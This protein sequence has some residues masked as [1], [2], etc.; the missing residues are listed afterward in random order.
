MHRIFSTLVLLVVALFHVQP[1][2]TAL[3]WQDPNN[4][5]QNPGF[6]GDYYPWMNLNTA[7]VAHGWTPWWRSR[8]DGDPKAYYFQ[9]E[10]KQANGYVFPERVHGGAAAQQW[11]TFFATHEAGMYQQVFGVTP[12]TRYRFT[13]WAQVWSSAEDNSSVSRD[14]A[15][16]NL[17]VGIDPTGGWNPWAGSVVWSQPYAFYDQW[18]QLAV[19]AVAQADVLTVFMYSAPN[20]PVKHNDMYW[21]DAV[22]VPVGQGNVPPPTAVPPTPVPPGTTPESPPATAPPAPTATCAPAP[23]DWVTYY[24]HRGDT[25]YSLAR[26]TGTTVERVMSVNCLSSTTI[27]VGQALLLPQLPPTAT[28]APPTATPPEVQASATPV[29]VTATPIPATATAAPAPDTATPV[30]PTDTAE[31][32]DTATPVPTATPRPTASATPVAATATE[33]AVSEPTSTAAVAQATIPP[34]ATSTPGSPAPPPTSDPAGAS[35]RPCGTIALSGGI[36]FVAGAFRFRRRKRP[37]KGRD[38]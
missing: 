10:Y 8:Q 23:D 16:P 26:V 21:D 19:E 11:F 13:A 35:T 33:V 27:E 4:L 30:P 3:A 28:P 17:R 38:G 18:G 31:P 22:L 5:L 29:P 1:V 2:Q 15:Y 7:Q 32:A 14:P 37:G 6:E 24:V 34:P 12:G 20:Y 36:V 25:L 9:P